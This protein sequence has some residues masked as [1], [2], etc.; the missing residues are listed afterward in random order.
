MKE[1]KSRMQAFVTFDLPL[2]TEF[3]SQQFTNI[4]ALQQNDF[5]HWSTASTRQKVIAAYWFTYV[6][7]H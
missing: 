1:W 7:K 2:Q 5:S 6:L 4:H 3:I